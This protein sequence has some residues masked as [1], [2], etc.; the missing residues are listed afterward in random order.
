MANLVIAW[1]KTIRVRRVL[2]W[3][4]IVGLLGGCMVHTTGSESLRV[5][6][7]AVA[8]DP[9]QPER[10]RF[11]ALTL[12]SSFVLQADDKRFGGLSGVDLDASGDTLF[13]VSDRGYGLSARLIHDKTGRLTGADHWS[14]AP[15]KTPSGKQVRRR[16]I[17]AEAIVQERD[18]AW[19]VAFEN[20]HRIWRYPPSP[21]PFAAL[22][23]PVQV[24]GVLSQAPRNGGVESMTR[25][26]DGRL[27]VLTEEFENAGGSL[28]GWLISE[29]RTVE[30]SYLA[31]DGFSPTDLAALSQG[32]VLVLER[33]FRRT[34]GVAIR[35]RRIPGS[36]LQP[37]ARLHGRELVSLHMPLVIDNFEGLA[38]RESP[39]GEILLYL[40]SDDNFKFFQQTLLFQF[41]LDLSDP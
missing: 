9:E 5:Q 33:R 20:R 30:V 14:I 29:A 41:R 12:L 18:G 39:Q 36:Q 24:P 34:S 3:V 7:K 37:G 21:A 17:D 23:E 32:D 16:M 19:L 1:T 2:S 10:T 31:S 4:V 13:A 35:L 8:L 11:G 27:F 40:I 28:K 6:A 26:P 15:L 25:L 38:V 22:P